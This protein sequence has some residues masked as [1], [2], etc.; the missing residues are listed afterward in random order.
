MKK[1]IAVLV[2]LLPTLCAA[3]PNT[4]ALI[5]YMGQLQCSTKAAFEKA[6]I[7]RVSDASF[8]KA[9]EGC[10]PQ[11]FK[12]E[13]GG[14]PGNVKPTSREERVAGLV[15]SL[16]TRTSLCQQQSLSPSACIKMFAASED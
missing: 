16:K 11:D 10:V 1:I 2:F 14:L 8:V 5:Q 9:A 4:P 6:D 12:E 3:A 15:R 7:V 13:L